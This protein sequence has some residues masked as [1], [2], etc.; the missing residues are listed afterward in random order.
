MKLSD[1]IEKLEENSEFKEW[2]KQ[3]PDAYLA[4]AFMMVDE[5]NKNMWQIGY[6]HPDS[7]KVTTFI[8]EKEDIKISPEA[9]IFKRPGTKVEK[10]ILEKV[11]IGSFQAIETAQEL[12]SKEYPKTVPMKMFFI[13]QEL[14]EQGTVY[15]ITYLS[16]DFQ[17]IN[18]R[19]SAETGEVLAHKAEKILDIKK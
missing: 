12:I 5:E 15:N 18:I 14:P 8:I 6:Y 9:N 4:H 1:V 2:R 13:I 16:R 19:I 11:K 7:D 3:Y 10:L 17:A